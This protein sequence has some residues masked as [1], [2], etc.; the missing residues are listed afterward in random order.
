MAD[1][2]KRKGAHRGP[3][4]WAHSAQTVWTGT[5]KVLNPHVTALLALG[6]RHLLDA[7]P[8][9]PADAGSPLVKHVTPGHAALAVI[10]STVAILLV[11]VGIWALSPTSARQVN[12]DP[13]IADLRLYEKALDGDISAAAA[14][15]RIKDRYTVTSTDSGTVVGRRSTASGTC[16]VLRIPSDTNIST[17]ITQ[18]VSADCGLATPAGGPKPGSSSRGTKT[19]DPSNLTT[20]TR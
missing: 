19:A 12:A 8:E 15:D 20:V 14:R 17:R 10:G 2:N 4:V 11:A 13:A 16:W 1:E 18:G 3:S 9:R 5:R 6:R 7:P